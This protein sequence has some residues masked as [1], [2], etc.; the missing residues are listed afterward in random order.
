MW[1]W[2]RAEYVIE[3]IVVYWYASPCNHKHTILFIG[4]LNKVLTSPNLLSVC[5]TLMNMTLTTPKVAVHPGKWRGIQ[6]SRLMSVVCMC[7]SIRQVNLAWTSRSDNA[8]DRELKVK[9]SAQGIVLAHIM[10]IW[11]H[12]KSYFNTIRA[13][14]PN[15]VQIFKSG[16]QPLCSNL[17]N[18]DLVCPHLAGLNKMSD[19]TKVV[20]TVRIER[21]WYPA[22]IIW[23]NPDYQAPI[24][25]ESYLRTP[26]S[27]GSWSLYGG[28]IKC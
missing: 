5:F 12:G 14:S 6:L 21:L 13:K 20:Y 24:K 17:G 11:T 19:Q 18:T 26:L 16:D 23:N 10:D 7:L 1:C 9:S 3:N 27:L 2:R 4:L 28:E 8:W 25:L 22:F 15:R